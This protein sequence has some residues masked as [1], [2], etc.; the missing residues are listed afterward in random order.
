MSA[1]IKAGLLRYPQCNLATDTVFALKQVISRE[2]W[3]S[4]DFI[5]H[6]TGASF[7]N[8]PVVAFSFVTTVSGN[9]GQN[10]IFS[11]LIHI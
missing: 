9:K 10:A 2:L 8:G 7:K 3:R 5:H 11:M 4:K 1:M 6:F